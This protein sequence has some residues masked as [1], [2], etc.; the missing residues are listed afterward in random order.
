M[1]TVITPLE[2]NALVDNCSESQN[3]PSSYELF[4]RPLAGKLLRLLKMDQI[5]HRAEG[6]RLY[7][8]ENSQEKSVIDFLGGFGAT[9]LGHNSSFLKEEMRK[10]IDLEMPVHTQLS[11]R[12]LSG[13]LCKRL[14][15]I[16]KETLNMSTVVQLTNTG[17]EAVEVAL[18]HAYLA[19]Q[20]R[21]EKL[22][23][24]NLLIFQNLLDSG[25]DPK[26]EKISKL[27]VCL[28]E[29]ARNISMT[30]FW[31]RMSSS[32]H[33]KTLG[34][35]SLVDTKDYTSPFESLLLKRITLNFENPESWYDQLAKTCFQ[36]YVFET[37]G[38]D[39]ELRT[40]T[41]S[42]VVALFF[43]PIQGEGGI[44]S[45]TPE[46]VELLDEI[47]IEFKVPLVADEIQCGMG[48]AGTFTY[49]E[50]LG[51][52]PN[53]LLLAKALGGGY[54]KIGA[55][56]IER[57]SYVEE[58]SLLHSST[59]AEDD[60]SSAVALKTFEHIHQPEF[61]QRVHE[62]SEKL[63]TGLEE[64]CCEFKDVVEPVRGRGLMLGM[65]FKSQAASPSNLI[66]MF[67]QSGYFGYFLS[68][69]LLNRFAVRL[70][71]SL[72]AA[73]VLRVE[74]SVEITEVEILK[75]CQALRR[76]CQALRFGDG[77]ELTAHLSHFDRT[78]LEQRALK[79]YRNHQRRPHYSSKKQDIER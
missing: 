42:S 53:Y 43:E 9:L 70:A 38:Q 3:I 27:K 24:Q 31:A 41:E 76:L 48:R 72:G 16:L 30:P 44:R 75:L 64:V 78:L 34:A 49:C 37:N 52:R 66:R 10:I 47:R 40:L 23:Q 17:A 56:C 74:P 65:A 63:S 67:Y 26:S 29:N 46:R 57:E 21:F 25:F 59:F 22:Q 7:F 28:E 55:A 13:D 77:F 4:T 36:F 69:Y 12:K 33:G 54:V 11:D 2:F 32:F 6:P 19:R 45:F 62:V 79:D 35:L 73:R 8:R 1:E 15:E 18:K 14:H 5:Y 71:P 50:Q 61:Y 60:V 68:S 20:R 39:I 51:L 58:F